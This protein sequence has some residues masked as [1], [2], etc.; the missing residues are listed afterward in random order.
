[1][2]VLT[3]LAGSVEENVKG[4][5]KLLE[6]RGVEGVFTDF[7]AYNAALH[8]LQTCVQALIDMAFRVLSSLGEKPPDSYGEAAEALFRLGVL[9]RESRDK[10]KSM[11]GFRNI[12][13]HRYL[14]LDHELLREILADKKF[15]DALKIAKEILEYAYQN[16]IDP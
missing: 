1:M 16:G 6:T 14:E 15:R 2:G 4:L 8:M 9:C 11:I 12:L 5:E 13:I 10:L 7:I 3:S